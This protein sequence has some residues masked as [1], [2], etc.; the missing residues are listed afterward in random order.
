MRKWILPALLVTLMTNAA[1]AQENTTASKGDFGTEISYNPFDQNG[2]TFSLDALKLRYFITDHDAVRLSLGFGITKET[3][4]D[5]DTPDDYVNTISGDFSIDLGYER[6]F[7][8][9][10]RLSLY[11]GGEVGFLSHYASGKGKTTIAG[12]TTT[13]DFKNIT[14]VN[15]DRAYAA[16]TAGI[17]TGLDFY[18]YKGLYLGAELGLYMQ[19][20]KTLKAE[21]KTTVGDITNI[22]KY[23]NTTTTTS[24]QFGVTP[25]IRLG[26]TF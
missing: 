11:A 12:T 14:T 8:V 3:V 5:E 4:K 19:T 16:F 24:C 6:H 7:K 10:K 9:A 18:V 23:N 15:G 2:N 22:T 20:G 13:I 1:W 17:F 26:W 21:A 25:T